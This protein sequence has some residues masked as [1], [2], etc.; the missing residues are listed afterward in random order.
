MTLEEFIVKSPGLIPKEA[1]HHEFDSFAISGYPHYENV[2]SNWFA[3]FLTT[4]NEHGF[5]NL[6]AEALK[7]AIIKKY[8]LE[9]LDWLDKDLTAIREVITNKGNF[10]DI[11]LFDEGEPD[12]RTFSNCVIIEHKINAS[13]Y[14]DLNDYYSSVETSGDPGSKTALIL[15]AR[16]RNDNDSNFLNLCYSE[17]LAEI[18]QLL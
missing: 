3:F 16:N 18:R 8:H 15:S 17:W 5:A 2:L 14:N 9:N 7:N 12:L 13:V 11:I 6:F 1:V 10:I 4:G